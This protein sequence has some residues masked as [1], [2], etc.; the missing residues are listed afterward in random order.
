MKKLL[1]IGVL[2]TAGQASVV[3]AEPVDVSTER[4]ASAVVWTSIATGAIAAGPVGALAGVIAGSW[5]GEKVEEADQLE[6]TEQQ[7]VRLETQLQET[8]N[9]LSDARQSANRYQQFALS[10]LEV[11]MF[12]KTDSSD[13]TALAEKKL[14][15]LAQLLDEQ[16]DLSVRLDGHTDPRGKAFYNQQLSE[17]R[18]EVVKAYLIGQGVNLHRLEGYSHGE[19]QSTASVGDDDRYALERVVRIRLSDDGQRSAGEVVQV[20]SP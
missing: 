10:Q 2:L 16:A 6:T 14:R 9:Q 20:V 3:M 4:K 19:T 15:Q 1:L 17:A 18:V 13:L 12:F 7:L 11:E 8:R 5:L